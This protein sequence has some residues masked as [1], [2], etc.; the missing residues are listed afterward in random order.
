MRWA[1]SAAIGA[2]IASSP[3]LSTAQETAV[4]ADVQAPAV[5]QVS[6]IQAAVVETD[7]KSFDAWEVGAARQSE[8]VLPNTLWKNSDAVAVGALF[9]KVGK[10][11]ASPGANRLARAALLSPGSAPTGSEA[12]AREAA[13]KRF[14]ALGRMGA[15]NE[16]ALMVSASPAAAADPSIAMFAAQAELARGRNAEACRRGQAFTPPAS[17]TTAPN[18]LFLLRL[19]AFCYAAA[20]DGPAADIASDVARN[21]GV[22]DPWLFSALPTLASAD[23]KTKPAAK[24]DTSLNAAVSLAGGFKAAAKPLAGSSLLAVS[25]VARSEAAAPAVRVEAAVTALQAGAI[26]PAAARAALASGADLKATK[27]VPVPLAVSAVKMVSAATDST[28]RAQALD[29]ALASMLNYVDYV[30]AARLFEDDIRA[31]PKDATTVS[32]GVAM[33]RALLAVGDSKAAA[34]WRNLV[35]SGATPPPE[36]VRSALDAALVAAGQGNPETAKVVVERRISLSTGL[37]LK[38]ASRDVLILQ[39]LGVPAPPPATGFI[40]A[41]PPVP[42]TAKADAAALASAITASQ[43]DAQ[44]ETALYVAMAL[45]NGADKVELDSV[46]TAIQA[47]RAANMMD[48][49]RIVA[50]EAM[51]ANGI[52]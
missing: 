10:P 50:V 31:L 28:T 36:A 9:D 30:A 38:R 42:A 2:L 26:E 3:A 46:V 4:A 8:G 37:S 11:F 41:N 14:A 45:A 27:A 16:I 29:A 35:V 6:A 1:I 32:H 24:Y 21:A 22:N 19:R 20:G 43:R 5:A 13:R 12:A 39:A 25:A 51:I 40:N 15:A 47:L 18:E 49:A 7:L 44:G 34:E 48:A 23:A 33:A 52:S 17:V